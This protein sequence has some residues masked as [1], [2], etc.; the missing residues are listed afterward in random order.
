MLG[1]RYKRNNTYALIYDIKIILV[2]RRC[3]ATASQTTADYTVSST[4]SGGTG[5]GSGGSG[6]SGGGVGGGGL[7]HLI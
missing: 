5:S 1:F 6:G 2:T 7:L 3:G 4:T